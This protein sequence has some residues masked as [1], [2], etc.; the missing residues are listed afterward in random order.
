MLLAA[1]LPA[2]GCQ[3]PAGPAVASA[4]AAGP[5]RSAPELEVIEEFWPD[6]TLRLRREGY[7]TPDNDF[8]DHG[9]YTRWYDNGVRE[10]DATYVRG[11]LD[12][13]ERQWHRNGRLRCEQEFV[14]GVRH[15]LRRV[16]DPEGRLRI[17]EHYAH[18]KPDGTWT[19][20]AADG[21]IKWQGRFSGGVPQP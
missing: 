15:G 8:V 2:W 13:V 21:R 9:R 10:Y 5:E 12:G 1:L 14:A 7:R 6:G 18:G 3:A 4:P 19:I 11:Q 17:E 20:W 16:W